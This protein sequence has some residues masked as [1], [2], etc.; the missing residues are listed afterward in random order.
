MSSSLPE[1]LIVLQLVPI[2]RKR[3]CPTIFFSVPLATISDDYQ[4][5]IV[6]KIP[7]YVFNSL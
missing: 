2:A 4:A 3:F 7:H 6:Y 5:N 1:N